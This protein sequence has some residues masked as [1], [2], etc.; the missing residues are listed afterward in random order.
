[1]RD[2]FEG[3]CVADEARPYGQWH[4]LYHEVV[5]TNLCTGCAACIMACP[6]DVL[7]YD[8]TTYHPFNFEGSTTFDDCIHGER[9][10][11]ICTKA[12]PRFRAW[13]IES[14]TALFGR[15]RTTDEVIGVYRDIY[16]VRANDGAIFEAGQDGGLVSAL[17]IWGLENGKIDGALTS[18]L[19]EKR[20]WDAEPCV[21]TNRDEVLASAGSR[22]TYAANPLAMREA[23]ARGLKNLALVGMSCQASINGTLSA[24]NVNKYRRKIQLVIGLLCSKSFSYDGLTEAI[25]EKYGLPYDDL[26]KVNIKGKFQMWKR[27]TGEEVDI[28]LKEL[29]PVTREGCKLCPD[30]AAEHADISTGG[31]GQGDGWTL[32]IVRTERGAEWMQGLLDA[33]WITM[34]PGSEDP[35]A[36]E[37]MRKLAAKSRLRWPEGGNGN[38]AP[39]AIPAEYE[40][41]PGAAPAH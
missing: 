16:L 26:A 4:E 40:P 35:K 13:E 8:T 38:G 25:T 12:C 27:S 11:D 18:K 39:R 23:E 20:V 36:V 1:M 5:S 2:T 17:L 41:K 7:E 37:L 9:G 33:G 19:S 21:V 31:L 30:F 24:R 15:A 22:Y 6:R 28:P 29:H 32:T 14:D 10:C 3:G 34:R